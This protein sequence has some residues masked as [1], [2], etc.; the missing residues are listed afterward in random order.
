MVCKKIDLSHG[1]CLLLSLARDPF[2]TPAEMTDLNSLS[3]H[4]RTRGLT[5]ILAKGPADRVSHGG[6]HSISR[7]NPFRWFLTEEGVVE[8]AGALGR[9]PG[10]LL[11]ELPIS[12]AWQSSILGRIDTAQVAYRLKNLAAQASGERCVW[13]WRRDGWRDGTLE[14]GENRF[15][16]VRRFGDAITRRAVASRLGSMM[17][18]WKR[19]RV[20]AVLFIVTS[21]TM[22]RFVERWLRDNG[23]G[24]YAWTV[25]EKDLFAEEP[26]GNIWHVPTSTGV[27]RH[28]MARMLEPITARTDE[29][30]L[31][32][33]KAAVYDRVSLPSASGRL[34]RQQRLSAQF[35][36]LSSPARRMFNLV[37]DWPLISQ[38]EALNML[39]MSRR[40]WRDLARGL[41]QAGLIMRFEIKGAEQARK[42]RYGLTLDG[43]TVVAR[44]DRVIRKHFSD[45]W[46]V[47]EASGMTNTVAW[48]TDIV[49]TGAQQLYREL[50]HTDGVYQ[51]VSLLAQGCRE[52]DGVDL[53]EVLPAHRSERWFR[54]RGG[55]QSRAVK[56]D[57][58][59]AIRTELGLIPFLLEYEQRAITP[60]A[61]KSVMQKY[62]NYF[63]S[64][65]SIEDWGCFP[66]VLI[67]FGDVAAASR[68]TRYTAENMPLPPMFFGDRL[69]IYVSSIPAMEREGVLG[70]VWFQP[71]ALD[72]GTITLAEVGAVS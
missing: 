42:T 45:L 69:P 67:V 59:G 56:P 26:L 53:I 6:L 5:E 68:F 7:K 16:H 21:Y 23:G 17:E 49:G 19:G 28:S 50:G 39:G 46:L 65:A 47:R 27:R 36:S 70:P 20:G 11:R 10:D 31:N 51:V 54:M 37:A 63:D 30:T 61:M 2:S 25:R 43:C 60:S 55:G 12:S 3:Q 34:A 14:I 52:R 1:H 58:S 32:F 13:R 35:A 48:N 40:N 71:H 64:P 4:H 33:V 9:D 44:Q 38:V 57:A 29:R 8:L 18:D 62:I 41:V 24:V 22:A 66:V 15:L 72:Q